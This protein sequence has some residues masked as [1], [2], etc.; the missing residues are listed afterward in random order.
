MGRQAAGG[1][2]AADRGPGGGRQPAG[3]RVSLRASGR[4]SSADAILVAD[5]GSIRA[6]Q[7]SLTVSLRGDARITVEVRTLAGNK[8]SGQYGGAAPDALIVLLRALATLWDEHGD[9]A[10]DGLRREEWAGRVVHRRRS[11]ARSRRSRTGV[12]LVGTGGI[13]SRIWSGSAITVLGID[14]PAVDGAAA[15]GAGPR[16]RDPQ[17]PRAPGAARRRGAGRGDAPPRGAATVRRAAP[18]HGRRDRRRV[19]R[20]VER[21]GLGRDG[22]RDER[23]LGRRDRRRSPP[24]ARS[25]SSR[26]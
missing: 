16:A 1:D 9:V 26:R 2:Q 24:A 5:G 7:P 12:P 4:T 22:R 3:G 19:P 17:R 14:A 10:V 20:E 8:H 25:R 13:G 23:R 6:G 11:S 15:V 21:A 18:G